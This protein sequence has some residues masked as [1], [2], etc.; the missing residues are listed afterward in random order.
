MV[1]A[2]GE[3]SGVTKGKGIL[4]KGSPIVLFNKLEGRSR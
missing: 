4:Q 1:D 2:I 3:R